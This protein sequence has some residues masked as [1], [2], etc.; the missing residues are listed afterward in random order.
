M[1]GIA[2]GVLALAAVVMG[3]AKSPEPEPRVAEQP[4]PPDAKP[5]PPKPAREVP[6]ALAAIFKERN[7]LHKRQTGA[8]LTISPKWGNDPG[9]D[10]AIHLNWE[11]D[12][13]GPR[14]PFA[15]LTPSGG[16][17][18]NPAYAHF[19]YT[20]RD[21]TI[22]T[23][24]KGVGGGWISGYPPLKQ[25]SWYSVAEGRKPVG[26]EIITGG[27]DSS[28]GEPGER[29]RPRLWMQLDYAPTDRGDG[30]DIIIDREKRTG[31]RG[32]NWTL[33]AWTGKLWSAVV[34]VA[35]K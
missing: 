31:T 3:C 5:E 21:G 34:E 20:N 26:G 13:D 25:R 10:S 16:T 18:P 6:A 1:R 32:P 15:I 4:P 33:D 35:F 27:F 17:G 7:A 8:L 29:G 19:W 12:Y 23:F 22:T 11:I 9:L 24:T 14:H 28:K 2:L 30:Y